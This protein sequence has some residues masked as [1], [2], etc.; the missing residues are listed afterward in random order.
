MEDSL[1]KLDKVEHIFLTE[2]FESLCPYYIAI[3]MTYDQ[4]WRDDPTIVV[5]Y[6]KANIIKQEYA[7]WN[8]YEG[9]MYTYEA[10]CKVSPVLHA[11]SK[12]GTKPLPF[13]KEPYGMDKI[14]EI[15]QEQLKSQRVKN[16]E[17]EKKKENER[18]K[19]E[20]FF[21]QWYKATKKHFEKKEVQS[22]E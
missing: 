13:S 9:G 1:V 5:M 20:I 2:L 11:F 17:E 4:Y 15:K 3:G 22:K 21:N 14:R 10:L 18:L 12:S 19:A 16:E 7:K 6:R 8:N